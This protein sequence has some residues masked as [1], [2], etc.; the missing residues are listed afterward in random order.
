MK[1]QKKHY[2]FKFIDLFAGIGG[3]RT[4]LESVGGAS[5][6]SSEWD[7]FACQTYFDNYNELPFGD[8]TK[9][10]ENDIPKHDLIAAGFPCQPFSNAGRKK[11]FADTRGT[12]FLDIV[13]IAKKHRPK[14]LFLENVKNLA[15]H[16]GGNTLRVIKENLEGLGYTVNMKVLNAKDFGLPQNR[17]RIFIICFLGDYKFNFP[18]PTSHSASVGDILE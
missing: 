5:A 11:G 6:F 3:I 2:K 8:I 9:I 12:L 14:V 17:E 1:V 7:K 16:D 18:S 13:R 4:G 15:T 10:N